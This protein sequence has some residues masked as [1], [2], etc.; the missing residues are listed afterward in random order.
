VPADTEWRAVVEE[1]QDL[2]VGT[3]TMPVAEW[4]RTYRLTYFASA[5]YNYRLLRVVLQAVGTLGADRVGH[6]VALA[7][8]T[9]V[10]PAGSALAEIGATAGAYSDSILAGEPWTLHSPHAG[11]ARLTVEAAIAA[12]ILARADDFYS[13]T[14]AVTEAFLGDAPALLEE[15][16]RYESLLVPR[17]LGEDPEPVDFAF[18]WPSYAASG[19]FDAPLREPVR[20]EFS[21]PAY[22]RQPDSQLFVRAHLATVL[23]G[24]ASG[25][26]ETAP[27]APAVAQAG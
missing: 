10:A 12:V 11:G 3:A 27:S 6:L 25:S 2:V 17:H 4:R 16:F 9:A 15:A 7:E 22:A 26:I 21:P 19:S 5:L 20:V 24:M 18:D 1:H 23:A 13:E 14:Q 8:A